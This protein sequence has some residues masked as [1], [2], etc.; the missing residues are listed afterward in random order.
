[1]KLIYKDLG[2]IMTKCLMIQGTASNA[3]KSLIVA[4]LCR[5]YIQKEDIRWLHSNHRI[6][7]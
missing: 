6:C 4:A 2:K 1:M 3:G 5:G 7:P